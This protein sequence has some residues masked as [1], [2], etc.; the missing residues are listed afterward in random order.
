MWGRKL[1]SDLDLGVKKT[2]LQKLLQTLIQIF[3]I[4]F[5][6]MW[7]QDVCEDNTHSHWQMRSSLS[8]DDGHVAA[9]QRWQKHAK[10][11]WEVKDPG[12]LCFEDVWVG[13]LRAIWLNISHEPECNPDHSSA[14]VWLHGGGWGDAG[15]LLPNTRGSSS[16]GEMEGLRR[17]EHSFKAL[18][19]LAAVGRAVVFPKSPPNRKTVSF[20]SVAQEQPLPRS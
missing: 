17:G 18:W 19:R 1:L 12:V 9:L 10:K 8:L 15:E 13:G 7:S 2:R 16:L 6:C 20:F 4:Y 11:C 14:A 3:Q 5:P